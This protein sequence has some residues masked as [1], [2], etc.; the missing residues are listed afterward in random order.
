MK[1]TAD[2]IGVRWDFDDFNQIKDFVDAREN[3]AV[4]FK[5]GAIVIINFIAV[6]V[7]FANCNLTIL[8][9]GDRALFK[10]AFI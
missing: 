2:K 7:A 4:F 5:L 6:P 8:F 9:R 3:K 1:L 10:C